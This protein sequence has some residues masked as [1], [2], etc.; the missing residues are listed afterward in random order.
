M[1]ECVQRKEAVGYI[2]ECILL[3]H[4]NRKAP[5]VTSR[6]V[7]V[8]RKPTNNELT[9]HTVSVLPNVLTPSSNSQ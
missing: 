8:E 5:H 1:W 7:E 4:T 9:Q 6:S 2:S 3:E